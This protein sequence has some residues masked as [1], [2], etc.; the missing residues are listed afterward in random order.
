MTENRIPFIQHKNT[1]TTFKITNSHLPYSRWVPDIYDFLV[2]SPLLYSPFATLEKAKVK[3]P[4]KRKLEQETEDVKSDIADDIANNNM[5]EFYSIKKRRLDE[6]SEMLDNMQ[7]NPWLDKDERL[8]ILKSLKANSLVEHITELERN[9]SPEEGEE[10]LRRLS[11]EQHHCLYSILQY[12]FPHDFPQKR[13]ESIEN[14][15]TDLLIN[16]FYK[17]FLIEG[18]AGCGKSAIIESLNYYIYSKHLDYT[19]LLYVTQT[20]V[21]CQSMRNKCFYN[22]TL[23]YL[24]FFRFLGV[25]NLDFY[26]RKQLLLNCDALQLDAFQNT[27]GTGFLRNMKDIIDLPPIPKNAD[28]DDDDRLLQSKK[29]PRLFIVFD[30]IYTVSNGKLSLFLFVVRC[31]KLQYPKLSIYCIL[32]GDKY[33]LRPFTKIE[34]IKLEV[35]PC[36][37]DLKDNILGDP[38]TLLEIKYPNSHQFKTEDI[39]SE[40]ISDDIKEELSDSKDIKPLDICHNINS[41]DTAS[42]SQ[43]I[44]ILNAQSQPKLNTQIQ[45]DPH[46][47][48]VVPKHS[49][50]QST[51]HLKAVAKAKAKLKELKPNIL[52]SADQPDDLYMQAMIAHNESLQNATRFTLSKQFRISDEIY[53][54]FVQ[55]VRNCENREDIGHELLQDIATLWPDKIDQNL[56]ITYPIDEILEIMEKI[57]VTDYSKM[58]LSLNSNGLFRKTIDTIVFCFTNRHA[59]YY[60]LALAFSYLHQIAEHPAQPG[61]EKFMAF[62]IIYNFDYL[63]LLD[64]VCRVQDLINQD[65]YLVNVL[66][67][68]RYCPY[69]VLSSETPVARL[70]IVYLLDWLLN[71]KNE[72]THVVVFSPDRNM[73]FTIMPSRFEMNLFKTTPLFGF[74]LQFAFSSTFASSQGLTLD[75]KI[76]ISCAN[77]SKAELYVCLTRIKHSNDLVRIY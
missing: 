55:K 28:D 25:L 58:V 11:P 44:D 66:P 26:D 62:S 16:P 38:D 76:A 20:N 71:D 49:A 39:K 35:Q 7:K 17:I 65:N 21:L 8:E 59:H 12:A 9:F 72:I 4:L 52:V 1:N 31:L 6:S 10:I 75:S 56:T 41:E 42:R 23:Q 36:P 14:V 43:H 68:V 5:D 63:Q 33:Q 45:P 70:S 13:Q 34:N 29:R 57:E 64:N 73:V 27:C 2:T 61:V 53:H 67:L 47:L 74:P 51:P 77:I 15:R 40:F 37:A 46:Q 69:K 54:Q 30:E 60:N 18:S 32:I 50:L 24:T 3:K 19:R 22:D 48:D